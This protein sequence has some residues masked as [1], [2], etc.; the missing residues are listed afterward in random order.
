[1]GKDFKSFYENKRNT[2]ESSQD[3]NNNNATAEKSVENEFKNELNQYKDK[4]EAE[5]MQELFKI[6]GKN[7]S[8][9]NLNNADLEAFSE[10]ISP[11]LTAE[12]NARLSMLIGQLKN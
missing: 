11:F 7:R 8:E 5:L 6:A 3:C 12:Q 4:S 9:G 10:Q 1:M 2:K